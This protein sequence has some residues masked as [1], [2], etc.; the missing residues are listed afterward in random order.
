MEWSN[1]QLKGEIIENSYFD[2]HDLVHKQIELFEMQ[3]FEKQI[4]LKN[5]IPIGTLLF[6]DKNMID[7][8]MRNFVSNAIKF[9][10]ESGNVII[11]SKRQEDSVEISVQD[12][13]VG[14]PVEN[15]EKIFQEKG[16]FT[17]LGTNKEQGTGIGLMLCKTFV[18]KQNGRIGVES[19]ENEGSRFWF[20]IPISN[21]HLK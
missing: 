20:T 8:I 1:N 9:C 18:G 7:I 11:S 3:A 17:T 14:I 4:V 2:M 19:K 21:Q 15:L 13:G 6:A 10:N 12:E 16:R 5:E